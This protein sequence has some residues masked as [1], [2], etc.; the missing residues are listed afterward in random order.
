MILMGDGADRSIIDGG[1]DRVVDVW[2]NNVQITNLTIRNGAAGAN[3]GGGLR[4]IGTG[5]QL[6]GVPISQNSANTGGR[7]HNPPFTSMSMIDG[8]IADNVAAAEGGAVFNDGT[9]KS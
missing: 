3:W 1:I 2:A 7:I 6:L 4:N 8:S 9:L 5:L